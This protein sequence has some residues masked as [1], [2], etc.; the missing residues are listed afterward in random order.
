[1]RHTAGGH[2]EVTSPP[3]GL[4]E[5]GTSDAPRGSPRDL[6]AVSHR[7]RGRKRADALSDAAE[8]EVDVGK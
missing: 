3:I 6:W 5:G 8:W 7:H 1:M 2:R 4:M